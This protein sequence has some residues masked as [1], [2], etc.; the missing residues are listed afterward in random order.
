MKGENESKRGGEKRVCENKEEKKATENV[1]FG[2]WK[3][4]IN[5]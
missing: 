2:K 1:Y 3:F 5:M 4:I